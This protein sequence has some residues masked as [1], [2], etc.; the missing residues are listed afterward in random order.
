MFWG[1]EGDDAPFIRCRRYR[2]RLTTMMTS[3]RHAT[4]IK[5]IQALSAHITCRRVEAP[6]LASVMRINPGDGRPVTCESDGSTPGERLGKP[7]NRH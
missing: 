6:N 5:R 1:K 4:S 3:T 2:A 7:D